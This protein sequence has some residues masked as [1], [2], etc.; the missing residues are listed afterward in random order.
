MIVI[1]HRGA[2][3]YAPENTI[4]A[5]VAARECGATMV[6]LDV[7]Q[8][9]DGAFVAM[10]DASLRRT[11]DVCRV[12]PDR[13]PWRVG[14][15]TLAEIRRLDAGSWFGTRFQ[16]ERV[17][18]VQEALGVLRHNRLRA[19]VELKAERPD[20]T[21]PTRLAR[22]L[23]S[24]P[25]WG[26]ESGRLVVQSFHRGAV[27]QLARL[28]PEAHFA[29]LAPTY[30]AF[31]LAQVAEYAKFINPHFLRVRPSLV[32]YAHSLGLEIFGWT[33]NGP[34]ATRRLV[35]SGVDGIITD[36]PDRVAMAV[37]TGWERRIRGTAFLTV[38][39]DRTAGR[40]RTV[41]R[42]NRRTSNG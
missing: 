9:A 11:T 25:Y 26:E 27:R 30:G 23:R 4:P 29:V 17:P 14:D 10:H 33:V 32:R 15:F 1:A 21:L 8:T 19:L 3:C 7:R 22:C 18:T 40:M 12:F 36:F 39:H 35:R 38:R 28:V 6:E 16:G 5:F 24:D 37:R 20:P 13:R 31:A 2:S 41:P 42:S 34:K